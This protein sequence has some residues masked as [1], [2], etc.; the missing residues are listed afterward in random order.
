MCLTTQ[1]RQIHDFGRSCYG[2]DARGSSTP[3]LLS[4]KSSC[5]FLVRDIGAEFLD[6]LLFNVIKIL[7][8]SR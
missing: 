5:E 7:F 1:I 3:A 8:D 4:L 2:F 6:P